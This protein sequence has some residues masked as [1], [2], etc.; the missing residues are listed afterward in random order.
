M[1]RNVVE[2]YAV[3]FEDGL[4]LG[5]S[6]FA[7]I[8]ELAKVSNTYEE[9]VDAYEKL[10]QSSFYYGLGRIVKYKK[11]VLIEKEDCND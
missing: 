1:K 6:I 10:K 4:F 8:P 2:G 11:T 5:G 3:E 7:T 9:A